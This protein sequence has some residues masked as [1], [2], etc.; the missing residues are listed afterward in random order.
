MPHLRV[1]CGCLQK[2]LAKL[3]R[4]LFRPEMRVVEMPGRTFITDDMIEV[5]VYFGVC[6]GCDSVYWARQG[7][8]FRRARAFV[9]T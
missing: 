8:P 6:G 2:D 7:P 1:A 4:S 9:S 3:D 5:V